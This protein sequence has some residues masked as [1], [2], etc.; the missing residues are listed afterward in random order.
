MTGRVL[1]VDDSEV[2]RSRVRARLS[3]VAGVEVLGEATD[4]ESA[5]RE[6]T[7]RQ[8]D[9]V[10]LDLL[11]PGG[12]G[13]RVL[14][15]MTKTSGRP[16]VI[17]FTNFPYPEYRTRCAELGADYF[18]DKTADHERLPELIGRLVNS[19]ARLV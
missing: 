18:F 5:L 3:S 16:V 17:V 7:E 14:E 9:I 4:A 2:I 13:T 8:P 19:G 15:G 1:L 10:V 11:M 6:L 12:G